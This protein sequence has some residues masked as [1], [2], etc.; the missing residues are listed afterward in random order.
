MMEKNLKA[1]LG[2]ES[3]LNFKNL[4]K[5]A[6]VGIFLMDAAGDCV[7]VNDKLIEIC[8]LSYQAALGRGWIVTVHPGDRDRVIAELQTSTTNRRPLKS[9]YRFLSAGGVTTWVLAQAQPI[10]DAKGALLGYAGTITDIT[11]RKQ[12]EEKLQGR[13]NDLELLQKISQDILS[14]S[15]LHAILRVILT[16]T[17]SFAAFDLGVVRLLDASDKMLRPIVSCGYRDESCIKAQSA[18]PGDPTHGEMQTW[19]FSRETA[20]VV[21]S[22]AT[23]P[24]LRTLKAEGIS[25]AILVPVKSK[26][27]MLGTILLGSRT[28]RKFSKDE[29]RVLEAIGKQVGIAV[30]KTRLF[31]T[32]DLRRRHAEALKDIGIALTATRDTQKVLALVAEEAMRLTGALFAYIVTPGKPYYRFAAVAGEDRGYRENLKLSDDPQSPFGQGIFG[33]AI[34]DE[35]AAV[36]EDVLNDSYFA[37]KRQNAAQHGIGSLVVVPIVVQG[38]PYGALISFSAAPKAYDAETI[39]LLTS[40]TA[41]AAAALENARLLQE[42]EQRAKEQAALSAIA[43]A[44]NQSLDLDQVLR[45]SLQKLKEITGREVAYIRLIEP[46]TNRLRVAAHE[47]LSEEALNKLNSP[48]SGGIGEKVLATGEPVVINDSQGTLLSDLTQRQGSVSVAWFPLKVQ[49]KTVGILNVATSRLM[50]FSDGEVRLL[51]AIANVIGVAI[52]NARSYAAAQRNLARVRALHEIDSA[53]L[54][55][56]GHEA[57]LRVL[58]EKIDLFVPYASATIRMWNPDTE[59]L[60]PVACQKLDEAKWKTEAP[61]AGWG[62]AKA[63][64]DAKAT[65]TIKDC[66]TDPRVY[67]PEFFRKNGLVSYLGVPLIAKDNVLGVISFYTNEEHEFTTEEIEFV[68]TLAGQAAVAIEH[69]LLYRDLIKREAQLQLTHKQLEALHS[70]TVQAGRSL[71]LDTV[72]QSVIDKITEIFDFD[73][74]R[75]YLYNEKMDELSVKGQFEKNPEVFSGVK[76]FARGQG[77]VGRVAES[78]EPLIFEDVS[79]DPVYR[80]TSSTQTSRK[81]GYKFYAALPIKGSRQI[82]GTMVCMGIA[83]RRLNDGEL[84]LLMAMVGQVAVA[85][86]NA[87]LYEEIRKRAAE[88]QQKTWELETA[89]RVKGEFLSVMSHELR[90]PLSVIMGYAGMLKEGLLGDMNG[91]QHAAVQKMLFRAGDQLNIINDIMQTTQIES[92]S[93]VTERHEIDASRLLRD[94]AAVYGEGLDGKDVSIRWNY[95]PEVLLVVTD[96]AKLRQI[97]QNLIANA[98]KFTETGTIT[99]SARRA[100]EWLEFVVAD[101][102][103]GIPL[104]MQ[105]MIF[106]KFKQVDSSETRSYGGVGLG[107]YIAKQFTE[108]LGGR[109]EIESQVG[110]GAIF[111]VR[112]PAPRALS[113]S[114]HAEALDGSHAADIIG[115]AAGDKT[116]KIDGL[117]EISQIGPNAASI[118]QRVA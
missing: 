60:E 34:R 51:Q 66:R 99:I 65:L 90:T 91:Q 19:S 82:L 79:T 116:G 67:G 78:G 100:E 35:K 88:L 31:A 53:I 76:S 50:P 108:M 10:S 14:S 37:A 2:V 17:I 80:K 114:G 115:A 47:G 41:Q 112:I 118:R 54:S 101:T 93:V 18:Q 117:S 40:L 46:L 98:G 81:G 83:A 23:A 74:T 92:S 104:D 69:S 63:T 11:E 97:L 62:P 52:G 42:T 1:S 8:G 36:C 33:K 13:L 39:S 87:S 103:I 72:T 7:Y 26:G 24:G 102:G 25:S 84:Q 61:G 110:K 113:H 16:R 111:T 75:F 30:Q 57:V 44:T 6:P 59:A 22:V 29:I 96:G 12:A 56:A 55:T 107:L 68:E 109:I 15:D 3:D 106:E 28:E 105:T 5:A 49:G 85:V 70:V 21:E 64:F 38:S 27:A 94:L 32:A 48:R 20:C 4:A 58:L 89:N 73:A 77:N 43:T 9:E 86:E 45:V 71:D 95:P